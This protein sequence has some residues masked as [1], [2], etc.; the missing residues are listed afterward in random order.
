MTDGMREEL[1]RQVAR[2]LKEAEKPMRV[3]EILPHLDP[4]LPSPNDVAEVL[5]EL[6]HQPDVTRSGSMFKK[7]TPVPLDRLFH[8]SAQRR[9]ADVILAIIR[10]LDEKHGGDGA[11]FP[12]VL[13]VATHRGIPSD[14]VL[15]VVTVL[16][17]A[18]EAYSV[19]G[20]RIRL[21]KG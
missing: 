18:G 20:D 8:A 19:G 11:R 3:E 6:A 16:R 2:L 12:E 5:S 10:E 4:I 14:V 21:A 17:N 13:Q 7:R 15:D 9:A 1:E